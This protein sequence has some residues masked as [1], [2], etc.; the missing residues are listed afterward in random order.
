[1]KNFI[2]PR[3]LTPVLK[4]FDKLEDRLV[5]GTTNLSFESRKIELTW[6]GQRP[7]EVEQNSSDDQDPP[8]SENNQGQFLLRKVLDPNISISDILAREIPATVDLHRNSAFIRMTQLSFSP[9]H[10]LVPVYPCLDGR[11]IT[12]NS[13]PQ[14]IPLA[15]FPE[16]RPFF[17]R[18][19]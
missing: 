8:E 15:M 16:I 7:I 17:W 5:K 6:M 4:R 2:S 18:N 14:F 19:R 9:L 1:M 13:R 12:D 11:G 10:K 3:A